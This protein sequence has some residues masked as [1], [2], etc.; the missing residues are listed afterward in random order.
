MINCTVFFNVLRG[1]QICSKVVVQV[2]TLTSSIL[3][4]IFVPT[5]KYYFSFFISFGVQSWRWILRPCE[6][7]AAFCHWATLPGLHSFYFE[8]CLTKLPRMAMN[9]LCSSGKPWTGLVILLPQLP[10]YLGIVGGLSP[11]SGLSAFSVSSSTPLSLHRHPSWI[12][13]S[14]NY[15]FS[16]L[17]DQSCLSL[18]VCFVVIYLSLLE[19]FQFTFECFVHF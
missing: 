17:S 3:E 10:K 16:F 1:S 9:S 18:N 2:Y 12:N 13:I 11:R 5:L 8:M 14:L 4:Y 7:L 19:K 15:K 6:C